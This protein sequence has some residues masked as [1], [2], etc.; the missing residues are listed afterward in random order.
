MT[1]LL[2]FCRKAA[3]KSQSMWLPMNTDERGMNRIGISAA[4]CAFLDFSAVSARR[5]NVQKVD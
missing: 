4:Q 1:T 5:K 3:E 2:G